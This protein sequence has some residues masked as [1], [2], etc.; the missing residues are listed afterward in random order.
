MTRTHIQE[1]TGGAV[2]QEWVEG[3]MRF[4]LGVTWSGR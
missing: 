2:K 1:V 4:C 3:E